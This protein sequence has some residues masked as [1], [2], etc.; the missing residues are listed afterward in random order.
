M[1]DSLSTT[2]IKKRSIKG[3][4]WLLVMN[5]LG[6]PSAF[7]IALMLGRVGPAALG[8]YALAQILIGVIT[9]FVV[10][11]GAP[12]LSVFLPKLSCAEDRGRFLFS[13]ALILLVMMAMTLSLFWLFPKAF[14]F[15][16]HRDFDMHNYGWFVLL[17]IVIV[18]T[19]MLANTASALMLI[20]TAAIARQMM[21]LVLLPLVFVLFVFKRELLV[22]NGVV[23]ILGG[24]LVGYI[25]AAVICMV[26]VARDNRLKVHSDWLLPSGF[27]AFSLTTMMTTVFSFLYGNIDRIAV[28]SIQDLNGLGMYQAVITVNAFVANI[29]TILLPS[30]VP[31]FSNLL[32]SNQHTAFHR[33]FSVMCR[34][35]VL[36]IT[37]ISLAMMAFSREILWIFGHE[38]TRYADLLTLFG[39]VGI[40]RSLSI[41]SLTI[42]TCKEKNAFRFW[43][44]FF[45]IVAQGVFTFAF[46]SHYGL[47]AIAGAKMFCVSV[48]SVIGILYVIFGLGMGRKIPL[49]Y[50]AAVIAGVTMVILRIW[51][52]P[53]GWLAS[54]LLMLSCFTLFLVGS[55]FSFDEMR[56]VIRFILYHDSAVFTSEVDNN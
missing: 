28:L 10:Y 17:A 8:A 48:S 54:L 41:P 51:V 32:G 40:I 31:T 1:T 5:A 39:L 7:L 16:L 20:K 13:Y 56:N 11:G 12:V 35:V 30:V 15:L 9:T 36:P 21:R 33:A 3:A 50:K 42:L 38:Y 4:K 25:L 53:D 19:E 26:S 22:D 37:L 49:S 47:I 44:S 29:P 46:M 6:L 52:V 24:F 55:Q 27:W 18:M 34:W 45:M 43:Q 2:E 23:C 14:E